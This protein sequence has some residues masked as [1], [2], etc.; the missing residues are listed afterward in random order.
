MKTALQKI[1]LAG[2]TLLVASVVACGG[3]GS[4]SNAD[5]T[6]MTQAQFDALLK[7]S[8][9]FKDA[10][11]SAPT[12]AQVG[13]LRIVGYAKGQS[14]L[15]SSNSSS[16]SYGART[17]ATATNPCTNL[18]VV[19]SENPTVSSVTLY[20]TCMGYTYNGDDAT[21]K[22]QSLPAVFYDTASCSGNA[23]LPGPSITVGSTAVADDSTLAVGGH[24]IV[25]VNG[26]EL[27]LKA[28]TVSTQPTILSEEF[29]GTCQSF[30][31]SGQPFYALQAYS[32]TDS[33]APG[34]TYPVPV[35]RSGP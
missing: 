1:I 7:T 34:T 31:Y 26:N 30:G 6:A 32:V 11:A 33:G 19:V 3:G 13:L 35:S 5:T 12:S 2:V 10:L 23:Y 27:E 14:P 28:G 9:V 16:I 18:G 4:T 15:D 8:T 17:Y 29:Q 25:D 20:R 22:V 21:G 24:V